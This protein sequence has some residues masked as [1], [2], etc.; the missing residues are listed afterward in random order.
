MLVHVCDS[1]SN[2]MFEALKGMIRFFKPN[3]ELSL[4]AI[5]PTITWL[6]KFF[7]ETWS[8]IRL[9][10]GEVVNFFHLLSVQ[11]APLQ[12]LVGTPMEGTSCVQHQLLIT[13]WNIPNHDG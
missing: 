9:T 7:F 12:G 13:T 10:R 6:R 8:L 11:G 2:L 4:S 3:T 1:V 5:T